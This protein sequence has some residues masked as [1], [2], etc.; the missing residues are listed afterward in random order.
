M[1]KKSR[2]KILSA[3]FFSRLKKS[4][5]SEPAKKKHVSFGFTFAQIGGGGERSKFAYCIYLYKAER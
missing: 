2:L 4:W 3:G 5:L 1:Y